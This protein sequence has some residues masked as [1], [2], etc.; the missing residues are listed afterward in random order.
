[1]AG[2][3]SANEL[4]NFE[5]IRDVSINMSKQDDRI[6]EGISPPKR[7]EQVRQNRHRVESK[8]D[9]EQREK[10]KAAHILKTFD[11]NKLFY[12]GASQSR[13]RAPRS[14]VRTA[15][16]PKSLRVEPSRPNL[17]DKCG[18]PTALKAERRESAP[19]NQQT[20]TE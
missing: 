10:A 6:G 13:E 8:Q 3:Q 16:N 20:S 4:I 18:S 7:Q 12:P 11:F 15:K 5:D 1:M 2:N 19:H 14:E 9:Q 17:C